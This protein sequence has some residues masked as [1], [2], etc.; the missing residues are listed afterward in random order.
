MN[1]SWFRV[2]PIAVRLWQN[3]RLES[4][5]NERRTLSF[6]FSTPLIPRQSADTC[7]CSP[8]V[9]YLRSGFNA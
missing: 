6:G 3:L 2:A 9:G 7:T 8:P 4:Q 1:L 5:K